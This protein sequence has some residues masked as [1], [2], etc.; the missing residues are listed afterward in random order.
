MK[1]N[2]KVFG[3]LLIIYSIVLS[4]IYVYDDLEYLFG[5][6]KYIYFLSLLIMFSIACFLLFFKG[7]SLS[8][9]KSVIFILTFSLTL[10]YL[11]IF[12]SRGWFIFIDHKYVFY[13]LF[14]VI[15]LYLVYLVASIYSVKKEIQTKDK[16][17]VDYNIL[18]KIKK[19]HEIFLEGLIKEVDYNEIKQNYINML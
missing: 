16:I 18:I 7:K 8:G 14:V 9:L 1:K 6:Y 10:F 12:L 15:F 13:S 11:S 19:L 2:N 5:G 4:V 3:L 17:V